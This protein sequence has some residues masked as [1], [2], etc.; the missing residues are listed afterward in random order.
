MLVGAT[1][2]ADTDKSALVAL[3]PPPSCRLNCGARFA[4]RSGCTRLIK[5]IKSPGCPPVRL[6]QIAPFTALIRDV[7]IRNAL[8]ASC[9]G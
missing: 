6:L 3:S 2:T 9:T 8:G 5:G 4:P 7:F 1:N